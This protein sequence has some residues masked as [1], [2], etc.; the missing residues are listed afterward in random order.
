MP[1]DQ[2]RGRFIYETAKSLS[3]FAQTKV[4]L[5]QARYPDV[6]FLKPRSFVYGGLNQDYSLPDLD[7]EAYDYPALPLVSRALNGWVSSRYLLPRVKAFKPDAIIG[8]WVYPDGNAALRVARELGVPAV[9]G[10]LGSDIHLREGLN[11]VLTRRTLAQSDA[12]IV[13]SRAMRDFT[14]RTFGTRADKIHTIV[15]GYNTGIFYP[16]DRAAAR[17]ALNLPQ[18]IELLTYVG[19]FIEAKGLLELLEAF[20]ALQRQRP[21]VRLAL[22]GSGVLEDRLRQVCEAKGLT[23][24]VLFPGGQPPDRVAL[25]LAASQLSTLPSWSEGYPNVVVEGIACGRPV[26]ATDVGGT[27]E[28][29]QHGVNGL[30]IPPRDAAALQRALSDAL[31]RAWDAEAIAAGIRRSWDDVATETLAVCEALIARQPGQQ[32]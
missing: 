2:T 14:I 1:F 7:V 17:Q 22:I 13:V 12:V 6:S 32:R 8:Y 19:R 9:I 30:L 15:N 28:I 25:W 11:E 27:R 26:V 21:Q 16:Q 20:E 23:D 24:K 18:D 10:A 4:F 29:I 5:Q 3:K 31:D